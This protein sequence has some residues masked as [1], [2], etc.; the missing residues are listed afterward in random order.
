VPKPRKPKLAVVTVTNSPLEG[1]MI[2]LLNDAFDR[3]ESGNTLAIAIIEVGRENEIRNVRVGQFD[4]HAH[5]LIAGAEYLK[6][7]I[8]NEI[9]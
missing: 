5:R 8:Y 4:G 1:Q 7:D 9:D 6:H 3:V 2:A